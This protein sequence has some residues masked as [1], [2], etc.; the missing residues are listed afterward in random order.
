MGRYSYV[1]SFVSVAQA[2]AEKANQDEKVRT[3]ADVPQL[4]QGWLW[5]P[6]TSLIYCECSAFTQVKSNV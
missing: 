1:E 6:S 3:S 5:T 4:G 2:I